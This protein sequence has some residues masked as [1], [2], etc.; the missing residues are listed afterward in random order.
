MKEKDRKENFEIVYKALFGNIIFDIE[1]K[2]K[3]VFTK[4]K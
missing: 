2:Y 4:Q 1:S 3:T